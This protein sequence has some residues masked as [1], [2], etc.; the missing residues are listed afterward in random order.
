MDRSSD[1]TVEKMSYGPEKP[2]TL[3]I[4]VLASLREFQE[5]GEPDIVAEIGGLFLEH[6]P[7]KLSAI[8]DAAERKDARGLQTAAH[9]LKSSSA[10]IGAMKLSALCKELEEMGRSGS[11]ERAVEKA[12]DLMDEFLRAKAALIEAMQRPR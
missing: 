7:K 8:C 4:A 5:A 9:S 12:R 10:Y 2:Q 3:D 6:S 1:R 11:T